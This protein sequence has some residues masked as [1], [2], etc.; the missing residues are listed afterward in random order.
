VLKSA[1][2]G[3]KS[4]STGL[5]SASTGLKSTST[6]LKSALNGSAR[7]GLLD[8]IRADLL[9]HVG[10]PLDDDAALL[11]VDAPAAW[12]AAQVTLAS[13]RPASHDH[14]SKLALSAADDP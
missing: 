13:P 2:T 3:L 6:G 12:P 9:K 1:S 8:L 11:L 10:A 14:G 4:A 7:Q 5:K